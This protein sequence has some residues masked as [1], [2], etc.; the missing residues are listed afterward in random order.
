MVCDNRTQD[1]PASGAFTEQTQGDPLNT[2]GQIAK[3]TA[4]YIAGQYSVGDLEHREQLIQRAIDQAIA[5]RDEVWHKKWNF[6]LGS[7]DQRITE[8]T[9]MLDDAMKC[10]DSYLNVPESVALR[11]RWEKLK[12]ELGP[13]TRAS[14]TTPKG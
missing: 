11:A 5:Y 9:E 2:P 8:M 6:A 3:E 7:K 13:R 4:Y 10:F 1:A 14:P 12:S